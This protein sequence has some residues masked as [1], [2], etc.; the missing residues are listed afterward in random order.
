MFMRKLVVI[1]AR[2]GSKRIPKKN[3]K[4]FYGSPIISYSLNNAKLSD[5]FDYIHVSTDD[6]LVYD[7]VSS[8]GFKPEFFRSHETATDTA[9]VRAVL[10]ETMLELD[11]RGM[12]FDVICLLSATAPLIDPEDLQKAMGMFESSCKRVPL[13]AVSKYPAPIEWALKL[14]QTDQALVPMNPEFFFASS[15]GFVDTFYDVGVFA[16]FTRE[17]LLAEN[18]EIKFMPYYLPLTK[19]VDVDDMRDWETLEEMYKIKLYESKINH[20]K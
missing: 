6:E 8:L 3:I 5:A 13:L 15:H 11:Q 2:G 12:N 10:K 18:L 16:F 17:H 1:P 4:P 19:S 9:P 7:V 14:D 20:V